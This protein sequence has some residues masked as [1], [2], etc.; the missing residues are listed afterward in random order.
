MIDTLVKLCPL[1]AAVL[2]AVV[3]FGYLFKKEYAWG[4]VWISYAL[5]NIGLVL[6]A[7]GGKSS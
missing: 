3:G 4:L 5:A 1:I 7:M 6:A 2:Y